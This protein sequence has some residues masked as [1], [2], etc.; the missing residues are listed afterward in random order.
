MGTWIFLICTVTLLN[1][2]IKYSVGR[3]P[4]GVV[5]GRAAHGNWHA[6]RRRFA[7]AGRLPRRLDATRIQVHSPD[8][9][10]PGEFRVRS[11]LR[12]RGA[13][14]GCKRYGRRAD[15]HHVPGGVRLPPHL[16]GPRRCI[17][18]RIS[19]A[20][21]RRRRGAARRL[22][23]DSGARTGLSV[24]RCLKTVVRLVDEP[25]ACVA[26]PRTLRGCSSNTRLR[27]T[28]SVSSPPAWVHSCHGRSSGM[29][30]ERAVV[31]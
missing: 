20:G 30:P 12:L 31:R 23:H 1:C 18:D 28:P 11:R 15:V 10:Q 9:R 24:Q 2:K 14:L 17:L 7:L 22:A 29:E 16:G 27:R 13:P 4:V 26:A 3:N 8:G 19:T 21:L 6:A 5:T 25:S